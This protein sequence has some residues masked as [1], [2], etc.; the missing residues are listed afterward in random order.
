[1]L[2]PLPLARNLCSNSGQ[3][4]NA[5][6]PAIN[7]SSHID[8]SAVRPAQPRAI[9]TGVLSVRG[10]ETGKT[11]LEALRMSGATKLVFPQVFRPDVET[12][13]VNTAGGITGGD[14]YRLDITAHSGAALTLTTQAA[15]RAYRAQ[16]GEDGQAT[17]RLCVRAGARLHWL[18]QELI[19]FDRCALD[20]RLMIDLEAEA[21]LLM[22]EP[23]VFGRALMNEDLR[24]VHFADRITVRRAGRPL[25][26]DGM[27]L[28]GDAAQHLGRRAIADG[29]GAMASVVLV[30][31]DA[32]AQ[33][34]PVRAALPDR[35]GASL[36]APDTLV[37]RLLATDSFEL[38][39]ALIPILDRLTENTLP[40]SWRL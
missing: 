22:V 40:T 39:R 3:T 25:Y 32:E 15:E 5:P 34:A 35:A 28:N 19:L 8:L 21:T 6:G 20:R 36:L 33:L 27:R 37:I 7:L 17:T 4:K 10:D 18:P 12:I 31:A 2:A 13:L 9:G 26:V 16:L 11:R 1:M 23:V 38:R 14:D 24:D 30:R 29:A